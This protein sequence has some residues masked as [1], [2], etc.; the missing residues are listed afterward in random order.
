M[1]EQWTML[2]APCE[3]RN[4]HLHSPVLQLPPDKAPDLP[5]R[6]SECGQSS[7]PNTS[8][9]ELSSLHGGFPDT[10]PVVEIT[11]GGLQVPLRPWSP[12]PADLILSLFL[13][14]LILPMS[15]LTSPSSL[16][17]QDLPAPPPVLV[18]T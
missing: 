7:L 17:N 11:S 15:V 5:W 8:C 2:P 1:R 6:L 12:Q 10:Q 16:C 4:L 14:A 9:S 13:L 18:V 3:F